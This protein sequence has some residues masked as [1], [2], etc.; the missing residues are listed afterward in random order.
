MKRSKT[1]QLE[2]SSERKELKRE[3]MVGDSEGH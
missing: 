2:D 3:G 1:E